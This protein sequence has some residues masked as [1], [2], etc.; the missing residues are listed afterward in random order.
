MNKKHFISFRKRRM[1]LAKGISLLPHFFT[2]GNAIF[3]FLSIIFA[4][5][6][7]WI[8]SANCILIGALMDALDGRIARFFNVSTAFGVELDSLC[9]VITFCLSPSLLIYFCFLQG[10]G[11]VGIIGS[12]VYLLAGIFRLA[13]FSLISDQQTIYFLGLPTT[14][15]ACFLAA[16]LLNMQ[17]L[18]LGKI[19][20]IS[21]FSLMIFL[22]FLMISTIPFPAFKQSFLNVSRKYFKII[23]F[24]CFSF[25]VIFK[26]KRILLFF[27]ILYIT[28]SMVI[29]FY[30]RIRGKEALLEPGR[31]S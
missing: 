21:I 24:S 12:I 22:S 23:I 15:A 30:S 18:V 9:D 13:R 7:S 31:Y 14:S 11:L 20:M 17:N 5:K 29:A 28:W 19:G 8:A 3:G 4:V 1:A 26:L 16:I 27:F 25:I 6:G 2:F 10:L